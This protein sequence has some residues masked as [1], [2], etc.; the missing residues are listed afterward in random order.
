MV[1]VL[2]TC[3]LFIRILMYKLNTPILV[4]EIGICIY[5]YPRLGGAKFNRQVS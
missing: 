2:V 4:A 1:K 3:R 5:E